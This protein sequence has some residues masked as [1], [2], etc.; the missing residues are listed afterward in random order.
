MCVVFF[1]Q[2]IALDSFSKLIEFHV[3]SMAIRQKMREKN[4]GWREETGG[5][6]IP[7]G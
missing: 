2:K 1:Q 3:V 6:E 5:V 4:E 7:T